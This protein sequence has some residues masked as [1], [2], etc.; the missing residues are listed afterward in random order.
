M[1]EHHIVPLKI[2]FLIFF[3]LMIG[4]SLT[5]A[6]AFVNMGFLNTPVALI[7]AL[8]KTSLVIL[9]FMHVKYSPKLIGLFAV[10]GFIWL[11]IMLSLTM[12]DYYTRGWGQEAPVQF[13]KEGAFF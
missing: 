3:A 9:F 4:T 12:Q 8:I 1:S 10:A 13:L 5:I 7:I 11:S 6:A 2:Y